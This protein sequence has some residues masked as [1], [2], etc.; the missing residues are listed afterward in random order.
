M[1]DGIRKGNSIC[2]DLD[3]KGLKETNVVRKKS[4]SGKHDRVVFITYHQCL[5]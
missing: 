4:E 3:T 5:A 2:R 1:E